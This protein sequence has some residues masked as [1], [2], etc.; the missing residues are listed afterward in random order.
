MPG[1]KFDVSVS[2]SHNAASLRGGRLMLSP[3]LGPRPGQ[4]DYA[5]ASGRSCWTILSSRHMGI[6]F[7][8]EIIRE[9]PFAS[10]VGETFNL[11]LQPYAE[12]FAAAGATGRCDRCGDLR[13][14]PA[15]AVRVATPLDDRTIRIDVP[16]PDRAT[17]CGLRGRG[18]RDADRADAAAPAA[19]SG[20]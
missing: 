5:V 3:L 14:A 19:K 6:A 7:S 8:R 20:R 1:D 17:Q 16:E 10:A 4:A 2:V 12:G 9:V 15:G 13:P 18:P 11:V